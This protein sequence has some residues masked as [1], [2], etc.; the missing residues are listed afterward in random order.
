MRNIDANTLNALTGSRSGDRIIAYVWYG[1]QLAY[2][3][4][5]PVSGWKADWD[6]T[7]QVQ[8]FSIEVRD[9]SGK[10]A[11]WL[12]EDALGVGG[13][14]L[15]IIYQVGGAG[16]VNLGWYRITKP[17]PAEKW[18]SYVI[19]ELGRVNTDDPT[20]NNKRRVFVPGGAVISVA[21]HDL[22]IMIKKAI[23]KAPES[24][25]GGSPTIVGEIKRLLLGIVPVV[26]TAGVVDRAVNTTL[27]YQKDRLAAV[28]DLC[29][30]ISC[31]YRMNGDGQ[32]EVYPLAAQT[33][34][35]T[36]KGG[37]EG[38][39]VDVNRSQDYEGLYNEFICRGTAKVTLAD[40]STVNVPVQ[41]VAQVTTG[42]L[43]VGGPHGSYPAEYEST[44]IT[45]QADADAYAREMMLTQL[46]G[47]TVDLFVTCLPNPALQQGDW[48]T[49]AN[50]VVNQQI[51][52][53]VG[54]VKTMSLASKGTAPDRMQLTV[55]CTYS[56]VQT[57]LGQVNRG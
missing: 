28:E 21:S 31:A 41:S 54:R 50:P 10:L 40:G 34:V 8:T 26:T 55:Q 47:L 3:D 24:P 32:F 57:A 38:V 19:D 20:P 44:M 45:S 12:L 56:D 14:R 39:L 15:Q 48:V 2:P 5:L 35:W 9:G 13:S 7:R 53:L 51:V 22:A 30:R 27:V 33:P 52:S 4:P 37:P 42:P 29:S 6:A 18:V 17:V 25:V 23:L 49:V 1:G 46:R 43:R 16:A 11:P 36:I